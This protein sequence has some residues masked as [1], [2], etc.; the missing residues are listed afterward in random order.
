MSI[1]ALNVYS[2]VECFLDLQLMWFMSC[3]YVVVAIGPTAPSFFIVKML[4]SSCSIKGGICQ[5]ILWRL[6][7]FKLGVRNIA[8]MMQDL[9]VERHIT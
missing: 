2:C 6:A 7:L 1:L 8:P 5:S 3:D 4:D 9:R